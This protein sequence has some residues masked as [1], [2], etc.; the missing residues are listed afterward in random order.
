[1]LIFSSICCYFILYSFSCHFEAYPYCTQVIGIRCLLVWLTFIFKDCRGTIWNHTAKIFWG[2]TSKIWCRNC[3]G[4]C[5]QVVVNLV[6][7]DELWYLFPVL[8]IIIQIVLIVS[9]LSVFLFVFCLN[10]TFQVRTYYCS[11][12]FCMIQTLL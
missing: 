6:C 7:S 8:L 5:W 9:S 10:T 12:F 1:M 2:Y 11:L 4:H 3:F